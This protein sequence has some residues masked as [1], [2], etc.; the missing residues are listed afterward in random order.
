[1][2]ENREDSQ[3]VH[4]DLIIRDFNYMF[5]FLY[6]IYFI[7]LVIVI[8]IFNPNQLSEASLS[9]NV[10]FIFPLL[11]IPAIKSYLS[12]KNKRRIVIKNNSIT[13]ENGSDI[14]ESINIQDI[15]KV[16]RTYSDYYHQSQKFPRGIEIVTYILFPIKVFIDI[17]LLIN[18]FFF[19]LIQDGGKGYK[20][21][22]SI[23]IF[24]KDGRFIN[25]LPTTLDEYE[26]VSTFLKLKTGIDIKDTKVFYQYSHSYEKIK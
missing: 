18:K 24:T 6:S 11:M 2:K 9:R 1:M 7:P 19:H 26:K 8:Y 14:L 21:F 22:D 5:L 25:I 20:L 13:L 23:I 3:S 4:N 15:Q 12:A 16:E 17:A 10:F